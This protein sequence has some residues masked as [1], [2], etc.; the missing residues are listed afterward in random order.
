MKLRLITG[1]LAVFLV[2]AAIPA[3]QAAGFTDI[4]N[5]WA[6]DY[7]EKAV[8]LELF[9][10]VSDTQFE[11]DS[12]MTRG[13]FVTVLGRLEG[14]DREYWS[15]KAIPQIFSDVSPEQ[16]YAP[17]IAWAVCNGIAEGTSG[18]TF[19]PTAP[20]TRE[21]I[22]KLLAT[23]LRRMGHGMIPS[24][25][26]GVPLSFADGDQ[27]SSWAQGSVD[28]L[29]SLGIMNGLPGENGEILF[30]PQNQ[31]TRAECAAVFCRLHDAMIPVPKNATNPTSLK[32]NQNGVF[33]LTGS[34]CQLIA[35]ATPEDAPLIWRSSDTNVV[36]VDQTGLVTCVG[37]GSATVTVYTANGLYASCNFTCKGDLA[38]SEETDR[39]KC[40]RLFGEEV[41]DPKLYYSIGQENGNYIFDYAAAEADMRSI[42]VRVWDIGSNGQ[43]YTK[44]LTLKVHK[45]L[46]FT[47][48]TI[49][50][51]IYNG[52]EKFPIRY[53]GGFSN[54][55]R[56]EHTIGSAVDINFNENYYCDP[57]GNPLVGS[58]WKPGEDP[59]SIPLDG[60]VA[61]IFAKYGFTQGAYWQS[62]YRDYMHFSY[63]GT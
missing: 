41:S 63:F 19:E 32:L 49:F 3:V 57:D 4:G 8:A 23:Y 46:A 60:E 16:Y 37:F 15:S 27:I 54:S 39:E 29:R 11:P 51:E 1:L 35:T 47:V 24:D 55:G 36:T 50:E 62:G 26:S 45:N 12:S 28:L 34:T 48:S 21:Q 7:I 40:I 44:N 17:Y 18:S 6:K 43:K 52:Q 10:G 20:I 56:S 25:G 61:K 13:M 33:L 30:M 53:V 31:L 58:Y 5:S 14:V 9:G 2:F 38:G 42:T 59:Y 22:A